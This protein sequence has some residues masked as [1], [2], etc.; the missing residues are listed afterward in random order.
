[1]QGLRIVVTGATG[2]IGRALCRRLGD[3]RTWTAVGRTDAEKQGLPVAFSHADLQDEMAARGAIP[4]GTDV[5]V[6]LAAHRGGPNDATGHFRGTAAATMFLCDAAKRAG[7]K[8]VVL[9]SS[10][11]VYE[12]ASDIDKLM[13]EDA[14]RV[15]N[16]PLAYG[17]AKKWAEDAARLQAMLASPQMDLWTLR[18]GMVVG[19]GLRPSAWLPTTMARLRSGEPYPLVGERGHRLGLVALDDVVDTLAVAIAG[20]PPKDTPRPGPLWNIVS[21]SW[22]ERDAVEKLAEAAGLEARFAPSSVPDPFGWN[23]RPLSLAADGS[24]WKTGMG[25]IS[26]REIEPLLAALARGDD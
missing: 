23:E 2:F 25:G 10:T 26:G 17:Y 21:E 9:A 16:K 20:L 18:I 8:R 6:H 4:D 24:R 12:P 14:P 15:R 11:S 19:P 22:F 3:P 1:M 13:T 5:L 7:V